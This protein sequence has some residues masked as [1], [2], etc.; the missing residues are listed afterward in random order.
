MTKKLPPLWIFIPLG[1]LFL[2][3]PLSA[4]K[5]IP[6]NWLKITTAGFQL[7][8]WLLFSSAIASGLFEHLEQP[9]EK[10]VRVKKTFLV[11]VGLFMGLN[12][13]M[14]ITS[15]GSANS[16]FESTFW[17]IL[18][19]IS[20]LIGLVYAKR[21]SRFLPEKVQR[22]LKYAW[23]LSF[24]IF[25][26]VAGLFLSFRTSS[27]FLAVCDHKVEDVK[28][29]LRVGAKPS[30]MDLR[31]AVRQG[32]IEITRLLLNAGADPNAPDG[33]Q[34]PMYW[35][36]VQSYDQICQKKL[37]ILELLLEA[38]ANPENLGSSPRGALRNVLEWSDETSRIRAIER[39]IQKGANP[40][41]L[42]ES[43]NSLIMAATYKDDATMITTL[44]QLG[45]NIDTPNRAGET[46]LRYASGSGRWSALRMLMSLNANPTIQAKD[47]KT[48]LESASSDTVLS[49]M[50]KAY[51]KKYEAGKTPAAGPVR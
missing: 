46:P 51:Q 42:D 11:L 32:D 23:P 9:M 13:M 40:N 38:G 19:F 8:F 35:A 41:I 49:E 34:T 30:P 5:L 10:S 44:Q 7:T 22:N 6:L 3:F 28:L 26:I 17:G 1:L 20:L 24:L 29:A 18:A 27:L 21:N 33:K 14:Q 45:A 2:V 48:P 16:V 36:T 43:G 39:M 37:E 47:G 31:L 4:M 15:Q 25:A 50:L 12:G